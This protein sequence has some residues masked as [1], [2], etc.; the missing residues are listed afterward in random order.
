MAVRLLL[1][2][3]LCESSVICD[4]IAMLRFVLLYH[5]CPP[6]FG[7]TSHWDLMLERDGVLQTWSL[8]ALPVAWGGEAGAGDVPI[9]ATRIAD[10]RI[11]YLEHEGPISGDRGVVTRVDRGEYVVLEEADKVMRVRLRGELSHEVVLTLAL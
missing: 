3:S 7:K 6:S 11:A 8:P 10:H 5:D 9:V 1:R 4:D 2:A